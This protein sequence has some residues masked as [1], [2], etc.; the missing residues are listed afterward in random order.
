MKS[1]EKKKQGRGI[2]ASVLLISSSLLR[3]GMNYFPDVRTICS[4]AF[5]FQQS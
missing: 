3:T 1:S 2:A 4:G 5:Q